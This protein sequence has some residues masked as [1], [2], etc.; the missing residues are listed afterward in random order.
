VGAAVIAALTA[1][2]QRQWTEPDHTMEDAFLGCHVTIPSMILSMFTT[3][4]SIL[5]NVVALLDAIVTVHQ[6]IQS[7]ADFAVLMKTGTVCVYHHI[8]GCHR[9]ILSAGN[10]NYYAY[11]YM[12][13]STQMEY[14][15][16]RHIKFGCRLLPSSK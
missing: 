7:A 1:T 10:T 2:N 8:G 3:T 15:E 13:C 9:L 12:A 4:T 6:T 16:K 5:I 14:R 11:L